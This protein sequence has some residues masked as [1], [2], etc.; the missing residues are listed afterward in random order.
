LEGSFKEEIVPF[1][2]CGTAED[3]NNLEVPAFFKCELSINQ[4]IYLFEGSG[5]LSQHLFFDI[6]S[7]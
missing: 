7:R 3:E 6:P 2:F 5:S 1:F 4:S